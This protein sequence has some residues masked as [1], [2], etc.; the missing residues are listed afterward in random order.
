M[1]RRIFVVF[2]KEAVDNSRDRRSLLVALIY[3]LLGPVLL[4]LM[5]SAVVDI[6]SVKTDPEVTLAINGA[7]RAPDLVSHLKKNGFTVEPA[8]ADPETAVRKGD[9][10]TVIVVS[11]DYAA[12]FGVERTAKI[13]IVAN[14]SRLPGLVALN[15]MAVILGDYNRAVWSKRIKAQGVDLDLLQPL[16]IVSLDV[17]AGTHIADILL[18]MVPPLIIFNLFM[19]GVY[20]AIDTTSGERERGSLEPLLINPVARWGLMLGK[21]LAALLYTAFAVAVQLTAFKII[22]QIV[23]GGDLSFARALDATTFAG[24]FAVT[25]PLMMVAVGVQFIIATVTRSFKEAQ[26]YLGL[27]PLVPAIPGMVLVFA[28]VQAKEWMMTIPTFS[29]TLLLSRFIQG[30]AVAVSDALVS[31]S[32]SAVTPLVLLPFAARLY[33]QEKLIFGT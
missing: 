3:P 23:G 11:E 5:I 4:G 32:T 28:P 24:I 22:F 13:T 12:K 20:M 29:Q 30:E 26:T 8:T 16:Q 2:A 6:S 25:V 19:G 1:W 17:A 15:R 27:L 10:E 7:E 9:Y 18:L 31:M 33:E 14:S 21:Y